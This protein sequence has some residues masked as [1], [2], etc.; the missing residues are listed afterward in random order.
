MTENEVFDYHAKY[1]GKIGLQ[2]KTSV[3]DRDELS[4]A[5]TPGVGKVCSEIAKNPDTVYKYTS[6]KNTVAIVSDGTAVLGLGNLGPE[7]ALPVMEG[8][9]L[10]FKKFADIDAWPICVPSN[11]TAKQIAE[12]ILNISPGFGGIN[13]ED[14]AAPKCFEVEKYLENLN[15][16]YFHD[17]QKGTAI[18]VLAGLMNSLKLAGKDFKDIKVVINGAGAAGLAIAHILEKAGVQNLILCD[19]NGILN[20]KNLMFEE[21]K[22]FLYLNKQNIKG[23]L[24]KALEN[25]D[26]FIGVSAPDL[27]QSENIRKMNEKSIVFTLANPIPE[28]MP[29]KAYEGGA[30]IVATGRSDYPNQVNNVLGFPGIFRGA[31]DGRIKK[32]NDEIC[33]KAAYALAE[34]L[35]EE[36][37]SPLK[38]LPEVFDKRV[39]PAV[40]EAV[41][42]VVI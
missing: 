38:I 39:V 23:D 31:F 12:V 33:L 25:S 9:A 26:V 21:Q 28:I 34:V 27:L 10:L 3:K 22:R 30:F 18:V 32:I 5:Y 8:K 20:Q 42:K 14:V 7:A 16:P 35:T 2:I 4:L 40:A 24:K 19:K 1:S 13:L 6:K 41:M 11:L 36:E 29:E 17:D 37:L 15:I